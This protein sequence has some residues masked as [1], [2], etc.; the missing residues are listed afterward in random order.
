M[1]AF[2]YGPFSFIPGRTMR[3]AGDP[4][5]R[6]EL[7]YG[8]DVVAERTLPETATRA[9]VIDC[10]D[11]DRSRFIDRHRPR[12]TEPVDE[13]VQ[14]CRLV[15]LGAGSF[16]VR[17][18]LAS[19][20]IRASLAGFSS[21]G[22]FD[23][24]G[25]TCA[26]TSYGTSALMSRDE[27]QRLADA[28]AA[29]GEAQQDLVRVRA[30]FTRPHVNAWISELL[31]AAVLSEDPEAWRSPTSWELRHV[32]GEGSFTGISGAAAAALVGVTPQNFRKYT[33]RD[34]ASTRQNMSYA[35]WHLLLHKLG[36]KRA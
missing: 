15:V 31:P 7:H 33:A 4:S 22:Y 12:A 21:G 26:I 17:E 29:I 2:N 32:V 9:D 25:E 19:F 13:Q 5:R 20:V 23:R 16:D 3:V 14:V 8:S 35:M 11:A 34:E 18:T 36:V 30:E 24:E 6:W 27:F 10:F 28:H 1:E